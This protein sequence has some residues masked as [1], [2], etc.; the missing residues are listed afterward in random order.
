MIHILQYYFIK[1]YKI[2]NLVFW[3]VVR[4][5]IFT[6]HNTTDLRHVVMNL[7]MV[8]CVLILSVLWM[9]MFL[10][11]TSNQRLIRNSNFEKNKE[12][13]VMQSNEKNIS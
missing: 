10:T 13:Y 2:Q 1:Q 7:P 6:F 12:T 5:M 9:D 3:R 11:V 8:R 4:G